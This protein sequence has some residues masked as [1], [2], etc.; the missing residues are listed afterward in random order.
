[1]TRPLVAVDC[2][3]VLA[4]FTGGV[5]RVIGS[6]VPFCSVTNHDMATLLTPVEQDAMQA[7]ITAP[8]FC[9]GLLPH[10]PALAMLA[11]IRRVADV[12]C[13]TAP[14]REGMTWQAE[15]VR[16]LARHF[17]FAPR[18]VV[19]ASSD[20]KPRFAADFLIEDR[21]DT[22]AA[23]ARANSRGRALVIDRP[24]NQQDADCYVSP[25]GQTAEQAQTFEATILW[26]RVPTY[27]ALQRAVLAS[28]AS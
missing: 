9:A 13:L 27:G 19:F 14:L 15:R 25:F 17:D 21:P 24:W 4:D 26:R 8:G 20:W 11:A 23:W 22:A 12:V 5:L 28:V 7:A 18:D 6:A 2:D 3:G 16:W 10:R 1:M